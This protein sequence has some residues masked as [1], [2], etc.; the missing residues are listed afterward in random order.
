M[1]TMFNEMIQKVIAG[2][3]ISLTL[4]GMTI[5][6]FGL[7]LLYI[8]MV[9][10]QKIISLVKYRKSQKIFSRKKAELLAEVINMEE[11]SAVIGLTLHLHTMR[12]RPYK[13][14]IKRLTRSTWKDSMRAKAMERL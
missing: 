6:Y 9:I 3:G 13:I 7:F 2:E 5:V 11:I 10:M 8:S 1:E 4:I 14:T 12:Y